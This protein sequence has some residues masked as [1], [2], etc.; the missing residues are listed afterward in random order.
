MINAIVISDF[1]KTLLKLVV[2]FVRKVQRSELYL[3][4]DAVFLLNDSEYSRFL[5]DIKKYDIPVFAIKEDVEKRKP[6][7]MDLAQTISYEEFVERLLSKN[8]KVI[9]L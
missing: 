5:K 9:N 2:Q 1:E 4:S 6:I 7:Y 8:V 3:L